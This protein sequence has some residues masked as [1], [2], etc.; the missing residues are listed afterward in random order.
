MEIRTIFSLILIAYTRILPASEFRNFWILHRW[1]IHL[2][3]DFKRLVSPKYEV[4]YFA[5]LIRRIF[6]G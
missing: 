4:K 2:P 6:E 3:L 1:C 5:S